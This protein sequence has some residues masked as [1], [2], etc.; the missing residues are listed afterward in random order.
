[1]NKAQAVHV[2]VNACALRN[3]GKAKFEKETVPASR[4]ESDKDAALR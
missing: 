1:M 3:W 2:G 4:C